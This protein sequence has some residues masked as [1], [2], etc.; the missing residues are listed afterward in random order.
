MQRNEKEQKSMKW[1]TGKRK[2]KG[3]KFWFFNKNHTVD[4]P[5]S[6]LTRKRHKL[7]ISENNYPKAQTDD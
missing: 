6:K 5:L 1:P 3:T 4:K 2:K 7:P